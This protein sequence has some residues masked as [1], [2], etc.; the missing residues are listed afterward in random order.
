[1]S[2][3]FYFFLSRINVCLRQD[4]CMFGFVATKIDFE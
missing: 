2:F 3:F 4:E 1:M